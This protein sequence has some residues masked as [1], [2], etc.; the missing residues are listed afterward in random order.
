MRVHFHFFFGFLF[1]F[2]FSF[3]TFG[4]L[5]VISE[6]GRKWTRESTEEERVER[7]QAEQRRM[8]LWRML[9]GDEHGE[10]GRP[11]YNYAPAIIL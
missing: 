10:M 2:S 11:I 7:L 1:F 5:G 6:Q 4:F 8:G 9:T 3:Y